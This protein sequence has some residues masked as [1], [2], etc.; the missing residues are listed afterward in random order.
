MKIVIDLQ[1]L[2][3]QSRFRGIGRY[4]LALTKAII[5][6]KKTNKKTL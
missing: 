5:K 4:S 3:T 1:S 2:Q 6:N